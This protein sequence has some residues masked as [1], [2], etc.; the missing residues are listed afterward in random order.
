MPN[1]VSGLRE[2]ISELQQLAEE[3]GRKRIPVTLSGAKPDREL[4]ERGEQAGV[5]RC[6]F[7]IPSSD[8]GGTERALDELAAAIGLG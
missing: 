5:H 1:R 2:R 7:Y 4:I 6:V 3:A 8:R